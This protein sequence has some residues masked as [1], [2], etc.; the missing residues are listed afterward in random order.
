MS[1]IAGYD[2][3]DSTSVDRKVPDY[4][5]SL[6]K[7]IKGLRIGIPKEYFIEGIDREVKDS[8]C[9]AIKLL[10][11]LGAKTDEVSLPHTEYAVSTYYIIAPAEASSNLAR[12]DGVQYGLRE[13]GPLIEM[14]KSTRAAGFGSEAKRRIILGTYV[15]SSGYY[16]AYYLKALKVRTRMREDFDRAFRDFDCIMT[17]T[18]PTPAFR[19][20]E[21]TDDPLSMYLSDI[22]TIPANLTGIPAVS[23]PC[24]HTAKGLPVG[25][26]ILAKPFDEETIL[27]AAY[28]FQENTD[29]HKRRPAV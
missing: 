27:R 2:P 13:R 8:V 9:S 3:K 28:A 10:G 17:P 26:Q 22:F 20:G 6:E 19:I 5:A 16:D 14:Y 12:F 24:G 21:R 25:L 15:L 29:F 1:A 11:K 4:T 23:I 7:D 18:S